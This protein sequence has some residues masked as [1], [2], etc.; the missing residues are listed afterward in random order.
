MENKFS[1]IAYSGERKIA[2]MKHLTKKEAKHHKR[3]IKLMC[4]GKIKKYSIEVIKEWQKS[5]LK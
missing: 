1:V 4:K 3:N 5:K 2:E